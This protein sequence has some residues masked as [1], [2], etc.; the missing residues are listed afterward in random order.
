MVQLTIKA[1]TETILDWEVDTDPGKLMDGQINPCETLR[2]FFLTQDTSD[3]GENKLRDEIR[4]FQ[5]QRIEA[6]MK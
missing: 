6:A 4:K 1:S 2:N 5:Q 3:M